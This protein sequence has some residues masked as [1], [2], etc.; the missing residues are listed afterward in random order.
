MTAEEGPGDNI[1]FTAVTPGDY[2]IFF[3]R[4]ATDTEFAKYPTS[5]NETRGRSFALRTDQ[6]AHIT[7]INGKTLTN[8]ITIMKNQLHR[9]KRRTPV[10]GN[11]TVRISTANTAVKI[12]WF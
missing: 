12:R 1:E 6:N 2:T 5:G 7:D 9:E 8:P 10:L 11:I 3:N 4:T